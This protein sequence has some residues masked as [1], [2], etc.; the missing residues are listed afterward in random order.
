MFL[1][2]VL[3]AD[4]FS[5]GDKVPLHPKTVSLISGRKHDFLFMSVE[6]IFLRF[7]SHTLLFIYPGRP[8]CLRA[9]VRLQ[10][11]CK[12]GATT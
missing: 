10:P 4:V 8:G 7:L 12:F 6:Y 9:K 3:L 2:L 11:H 1:N 5:R